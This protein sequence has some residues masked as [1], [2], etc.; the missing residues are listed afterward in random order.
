MGHE[1][2]SSVPLTISGQ[3]RLSLL[4]VT[5]WYPD[6]PLN[7]SRCR[8]HH[9][10]HALNKVADI[11]LLTFPPPEGPGSSASLIEH[12]YCQDA[13]V[14]KTLP[15]ERNPLRHW[16]G[17]FARTPRDFYAFRSDELR[18]VLERLGREQS[19]DV[20]VASTLRVAADALMVPAAVHVLE[21][22]NFLG[23]QLAEPLQEVNLRILHRWR[24][25]MRLAKDLAYERRI[26]AHYDLV[27]MVSE[28]DRQAV[29]DTGCKPADI[30]VVPNGVELA[31]EKE[32]E[33]QP[34]PNTLL[35]CGS[36]TYSANEDAV[37]WFLDAIWPRIRGLKPDAQFRI[38]GSTEGVDIS[39]F[40]DIEGLEFLGFVENI[41]ECVA[42]HWL[43]VVPLR[44]GGGTRLKVLESMALGTPV[45]TTSK[46]AEGL[47]LK[48]DLEA[49]FADDPDAFAR[50][51]VQIL[52]DRSLRGR[53]SEA[54]RL[55]AEQ[56]YDWRGISDKFSRMV[57]DLVQAKAARR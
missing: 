37:A 15:Y 2:P 29:I 19:F 28:Q 32:R 44:Q 54:G 20:V 34:E 26:Y 46:G 12:R 49:S 43:S 48:P 22:H 30:A 9:L 39:R 36:M 6:P 52:N 47:R 55:R 8:V 5:P 25:R 23:R 4:F 21:E 51:V 14:L 1:H 27:T 24:L 17:L 42:Q 31:T 35:Y 3:E 45:V 16:L 10:L 11:H 7:G 40:A 53:L 41:R 56:D 38:T 57:H 50:S 13:T 18:Q 33:I